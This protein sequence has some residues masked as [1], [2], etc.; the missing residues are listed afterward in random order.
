MTMS[1]ITIPTTEHRF[2]DLVRRCRGPVLV[3]GDPGYD[4]AR[5]AWNLT[6]DQR[7]AAI[8]AAHDASDVVAAVDAA[9]AA[10]L[11]VAVQ[12]TG[13]GS[14]RPADG[15]LLVLTAGLDGVHIDPVARTARVGGGVRWGAVL[16]AA[17]QHGLAPLVGSSTDVGA[18]GYTLGGGMGW[19]ARRFGLAADHLRSVELVTPEARVVEVSAETD[20][21]LFWALQGAGA[22]NFGVVT[23]MEIG[24]VPVSTVYAGNLLYPVEAA[25]EILARWR[26][27]VDGVG[28]ELTSAVC[29][30]NFP[31]LDE[32]PE[33]VRGRSF[34]IVRGCWSGPLDEGR[35]LIDQW[36]AWRTPEIDLFGPMRLTHADT[37][38]NDPT[39]PIP[40][41]ISTEWFDDLPDA[42]VDV[43]VR[44]TFVAGPPP[45]VFAELR[46]GGGA[47][48]RSRAAIDRGRTGR[49]VLT[50][51]AVAHGP[52][53]APAAEGY[54]AA[55]RADLA[56]WANGS[57]FPNFTDGGERVARAATT[58]FTDTTLA[59]LRAV[60]RRIDPADVFGFGGV[61]LADA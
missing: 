26:E 42:A 21:D 58:A 31:P 20:P 16:A 56:P 36:R 37:I 51:L 53:G 43:L 25:S 17:Q 35:V 47:I 49:F 5:A 34:V 55:T 14:A 9:R 32:V 4:E 44:R 18:V 27:W 7:P 28:E 45:L 60:K 6:V 38:S 13:H 59:R 29:L 8:V 52:D 24:L 1:E 2:A 41:T 19:L 30:M 48:E 40:Y 22:G 10:G 54:V 23:A 50:M 33:P 12:T 61:A 11:R 15:A 57:T 39:H 46:H 3:P